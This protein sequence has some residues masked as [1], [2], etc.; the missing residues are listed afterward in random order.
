[1]ATEYIEPQWLLPNELNQAIPAD[2]ATGSGLAEDRQ[3]LYSMK[4]DGAVDRVDCGEL[5]SF[6]NKL[7]ISAW[8]YPTITDSYLRNVIIGKN[9]PNYGGLGN[10]G[11][12]LQLSVKSSGEIMAQFWIG[13]QGNTPD[14]GVAQ[15]INYGSGYTKDSWYHLV[16]TWDGTDMKLYLNGNTTPIA[17][18]TLTTNITYQAG[19][20]TQIGAVR[21]T[22]NSWTGNIDEVAL[23]DRALSSDEV[24]DLWNSGSPG[25]AMTLNPMVYYPLGEQA[26]AAGSLAAGTADWQFPNQSLESYA[27]NFGASS[28]QYIE[29]G[30]GPTLSGDANISFWYN[31]D[32]TGSTYEGILSSP[33]YAKAGFRSWS[34]QQYGNITTSGYLR[35]AI[36]NTD[37]TYYI[38]PSGTSG[39]GY[40][41]LVPSTWYHLC[42]VL[43]TAANVITMYIDGVAE[44]STMSVTGGTMNGNLEDSSNGIMMGMYYNNG[45]LSA[46]SEFEGRLSNML[47]WDSAL[48][49]PNVTTLYNNGIPITTLADFPNSGDVQAWWKLNSSATFDSTAIEWTIPDDSTNSNTGTSTGMTQASLVPSDLQF[50]SPYSNFS[51]DFFG[52]NDFIGLDSDISISGNKTVSF[53]INPTVAA[54]GGTGGIIF[55]ATSSYYYPYI[56]NDIIY[57]NDSAVGYGSITYSTGF[58]AG[59]WYNICISGNG[60]LATVYING[61]SIGTMDDVDIEACNTIAAYGNNSFAFNGKMSNFAIWD[62]ALTAAQ[63]T[64]VYNNG[65]PRDLT[66]LSPISWWRLGEDAYF[67]SPDFII[68]NKITGAPNGTSVSIPSTALMAN[69][70]GSFGAGLGSSLVVEDRIGDAKESTGNSVSYNMIPANR[71]TYPGGYVPTQ[72][73]NDWAMEFDGLNDRIW[74]NGGIDIDLGTTCTLSFWMKGATSYNGFIFGQSGTN[75]GVIWANTTVF[76]FYVAGAWTA[77]F[78]NVVPLLTANN[79]HHVAITRDGTS[80]SVYVNGSFVETLTGSPFTASTLINQIGA[81]GNPTAAINSPWEGQLDEVAFWNTVLSARQIKQDIYGGGRD[82]KCADLNNISNLTAPVAWYRMGD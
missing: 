69:A 26:R 45:S 24:Q 77:N 46:G 13:S 33:N 19:V 35:L 29:S 51:L 57:I 68:P 2:G 25:N 8:A 5:N 58:N 67:V 71:I 12:N 70:P 76:H 9:Y 42:F 55:G 48:S 73:D 72:V 39:W 52:T 27:F 78:T 20:Q 36:Y 62:S 79:W 44:A 40:G 32:N 7:S 38:S 23:F 50:E 15:V 4:F 65:Y 34:F 6:T 61:I 21:D 74:V 53:W 75:L 47:A 80:V 31:S 64:Q 37:S 49:A 56:Q 43:D 10:K 54:F 63:V 16:G 82:P 41:N 18:A 22:Y 3:S 59:E 30:T 11:Y 28:N 1:M 66:F 14:V 81:R 60:T 17:T